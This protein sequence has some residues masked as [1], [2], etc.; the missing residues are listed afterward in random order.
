[1]VKHFHKKQE[2]NYQKVVKHID[3]NLR[4]NAVLNRLNLKDPKL[5]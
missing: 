3:L 4:I 1:M 2:L 5:Y